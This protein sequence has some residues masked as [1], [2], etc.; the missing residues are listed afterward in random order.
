[1]D[2]DYMLGIDAGTSVVKAALF[3]RAG[4]EQAVAW[5]PNRAKSPQPTWSEVSMEETWAVTCAAIQELVAKRGIDPQRIAGVGVTGTMVGAWPID[6]RGRPVRDAILWNDGRTQ[7]LMERLSAQHPNFMSTIFQESG[8]VMQQGCTLPVVRWLADHEPETLARTQAI[9][10][11]KDWLCYRLTGSIQLDPTEVTVMPGDARGRTYSQAMFDLFELA[12]YRHLFPPIRQPQ[13]IIGHVLP[14]AAAQTGLPVGTAVIA[15]V[16]DVPAPSIGLGA[17]KPG[18]ACTLLGTN[19]LNCLVMAE[20]VFEPA[21]VGLL[22]CAPGGRWL[23]AMVNVSGT[24]SLDWFIRTFYVPEAAAAPSQ[25]E[26]FD[27][28][29]ELARESPPGANG[30]IYLPYLSGLGITTPFSEPAARA[31]F[32]GL[33]DAH[34]HS[35][36][37]RAVYEGIALSIRDGYHAM[38]RPI[39]E[40]RLSGGGSKSFFWSQLI[41]DCT[42]KRVV[43]PAGKEFGARG[44]AL[45]AGLAL[46]WYASI[47]EASQTGLVRQRVYEPDPTARA[48]YD[49]IFETYC[50]LRDNLRPAWRHAAKN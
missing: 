14:Q 2:A 25:A 3:D 45:L 35:D 39:D 13:E 22:F 37:L 33:T 41:A 32:F 17:V 40:I 30:V 21:D 47:D 23:R 10:C 18:M 11:C 16:G 27:R 15:G 46:G 9:L 19:I 7:P 6:A 12:R 8:S 1:M 34:R 20:P 4:N 43:V 26:L 28:L 5:Q 49:D 29:E 44:V 42:G 50:L 38:G 48:I 31:Q 36:L 24:A